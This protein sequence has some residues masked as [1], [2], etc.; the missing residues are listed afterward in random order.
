MDFDEAEHGDG[1]EGE[2]QGENIEEAL[3]GDG[4]GGIVIFIMITS[5]IISNKN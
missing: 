3:F 4:E 1:D 2:E 5:L